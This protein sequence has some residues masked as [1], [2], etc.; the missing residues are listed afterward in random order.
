M[1]T[2]P[3]IIA[4]GDIHGCALSNHAL[5]KKLD[6]EYSDQPTYVFLG[7]YTDRGPDSK[8]VVDQLIKFNKDHECVFLK[9]NHDQ[10]LLNAYEKGDWNLW[11]SN[12]GN[13]T[14]KNYDSSPGDFKLP[15]DHYEFF[16]NTELYWETE[17]YFF[18]HGGISPDLTIQEN[19]DSEYERE[20]FI[21]QRDHVYARTN[22]WSK[23]VV[24]GHTPVKEPIVEENMLGIDT[25]CVYKKKGY[26]V[27]TAVALPEMKFIEQNCLDF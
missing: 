24:F 3:D 27:L 16:K 23:T 14:L 2:Y 5:L 1:A 9:G 12:G 6:S 22:K 21:W 25:G 7:D 13:T 17:S 8:K 18:V 4:I 15:K 20:Q 26:G 19:L 11:L 10:M